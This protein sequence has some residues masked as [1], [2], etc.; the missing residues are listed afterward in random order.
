MIVAISPIWMAASAIALPVKPAAD[1]SQS[2]EQQL[3]AQSIYRGYRRSPRN[4]RPSNSNY[5][6]RH[7]ESISIDAWFC[8]EWVQ[9]LY[10]HRTKWRA[11]PPPD[12]MIARLRNLSSAAR[13]NLG[14]YSEDTLADQN[15]R[16]VSLGI[17]WREAN[18][19]A[20]RQFRSLFPERWAALSES[21]W[22]T[23]QIWQ[24]IR[25]DQITRMGRNARRQA[26]FWSYEVEF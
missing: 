2:T 16:L 12:R 19:L 21:E 8:Q 22:Y 1:L 20:N 13:R 6:V 15:W 3:L 18:E 17:D 7:C 9:E 4:Y 24:A 10:V 26:P 23:R 14:S 25:E 5:M 11:L